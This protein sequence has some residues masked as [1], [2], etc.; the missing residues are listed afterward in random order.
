MQ[1]STSIAQSSVVKRSV[2]LNGHKTSVSLEDVFWNA[3]KDIATE[4]NLAVTALIEAID[5]DR[6]SANLSSALRQYI[7]MHFY[8]RAQKQTE[9]TVSVAADVRPSLWS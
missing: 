8:Q 6:G 5:K 7:M 4:K 3:M 2:A 9:Q 1:S